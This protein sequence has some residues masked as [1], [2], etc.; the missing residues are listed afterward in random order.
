MKTRPDNSFVRRELFLDRMDEL[1]ALPIAGY[2][3][4]S[5]DS[6]FYIL[7]EELSTGGHFSSV[8]VSGETI[9]G[10]M[11]ASFIDCG[12]DGFASIYEHLNQTP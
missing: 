11:A 9:I 6:G 7:A 10:L 4:Y 5:D 1:G 3:I 8:A 2:I 12:R